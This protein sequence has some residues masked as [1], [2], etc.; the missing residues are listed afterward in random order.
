MVLLIISACG[1]L[2]AVFSV[3]LCSKSVSSC[4]S[5][6]VCQVRSSTILFAPFNEPAEQAEAYSLGRELQDIHHQ[7]LSP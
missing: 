3:T 5:N 6:K 4:F 1:F 7:T 2:P